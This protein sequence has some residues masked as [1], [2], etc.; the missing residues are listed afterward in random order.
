MLEPPVERVSL[1]LT[2]LMA[3]EARSSSSWVPS[4]APAVQCRG[5][6]RCFVPD[7][8]PPDLTP[9]EV[10][11]QLRALGLAPLDD[12]DLTEV[13]HRINAINEAALALEDPAA[14]AIEPVPVFW[15]DPDAWRREEGADGR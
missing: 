5:P 13:T 14:D 7:L 6:R 9:E 8:T 10:R 1:A 4:H 3:V 11:A 2:G 12:D 15:L